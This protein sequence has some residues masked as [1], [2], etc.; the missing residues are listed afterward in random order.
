MHFQGLELESKSYPKTKS[1]VV[2]AVY[3]QTALK[4]LNN[5][6]GEK[7]TKTTYM[8]AIKCDILGAKLQRNSF[9]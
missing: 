6:K 2:H 7:E 1:A 4:Q 8:L 5:N 9:L 3:R